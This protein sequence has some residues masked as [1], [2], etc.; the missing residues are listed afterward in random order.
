MTEKGETILLKQT[1]PNVEKI[2]Q[3]VKW[4][5]ENS[6]VKNKRENLNILINKKIFIK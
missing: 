1:K 2:L 3:Q 6:V 5:K 4:V